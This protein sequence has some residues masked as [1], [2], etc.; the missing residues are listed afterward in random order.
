MND[1]LRMNIFNTFNNLL[2]NFRTQQY[3]DWNKIIVSGV[4]PLSKI[5]LTQLHLDIKGSVL[6]DSDRPRV[7]KL[8]CWFSIFTNDPVF[9]AHA[10]GIFRWAS[11]SPFYLSTLGFLHRTRFFIRILKYNIEGVTRG[12]TSKNNL[13]KQLYSQDTKQIFLFVL[14]TSSPSLH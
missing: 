6:V 12:A 11:F 7:I 14:T 10:S 9:V 13:K 4:Q 2:E 3:V 1:S 8:V 5:C